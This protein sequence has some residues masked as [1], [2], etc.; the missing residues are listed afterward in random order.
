VSKIAARKSFTGVLQFDVS[1]GVGNFNS[2][3]YTTTY[4][5]LD[6]TNQP[7]RFYCRY[8][9][10]KKSVPEEVHRESGT[11]GVSKKK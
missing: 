10:S 6:S 7:E 4:S 9:E 8:Q 5:S 3:V 11:V 1:I 2:K